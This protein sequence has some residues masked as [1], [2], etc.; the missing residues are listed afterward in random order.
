MPTAPRP[1]SDPDATEGR[2]AA[3]AGSAEP[4]RPSTRRRFLAW[5]LGTAVVAAA[6]V[7][8]VE[9]VDRGVLP[10]HGM[11]LTVEG[12]CAVA[13]PGL[14]FSTPGPASSGR[15]L[16]RARR[17]VVGYTIAYP[18]GHGPGS[19]LPLIVMLHGYG[20]DHTD[21]LSG[22]SPAQAVAIK[23]D[24]RP[25]VPMAMVTVDGGGGYWHP[26]PGDDPLGMVVD[27]LIPMCRAR[28]LGRP[29][30]GLATMGIS[31]GGYGALVVAERYPAMV[32]AVA[33][34]SPAVWTTYAEAHGANPG[35]Y[36]SARDFAAYDAVTHASALAGIPVR[37]ASGLD[38][39][40][41]PGVR[42]LAASLHHATVD[43]S[44]GCHSG[45]F[46]VAQEPPSLAFLSDH[47]GG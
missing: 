21:A 4:D 45:P 44:K 6:G 7:T 25:L 43:F 26:H 18:P 9:L 14:E 34:I 10:G 27:E 32:R 39:P 13:S 33:A 29:A 47:L 40:F 15:F 41:Q 31:M 30:Q 1:R 2:G 16:S 37:V 17:R 46:F 3:P 23:V 12:A 5:G 20:A 38:D 8:G 22:M 28:G 36:S 42:A 11:L 24:G 35:A 19:V